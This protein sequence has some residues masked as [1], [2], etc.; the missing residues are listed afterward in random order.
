LLFSYARYCSFSF[1]GPPKIDLN[2]THLYIT[3]IS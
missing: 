3:I 2:H 1:I